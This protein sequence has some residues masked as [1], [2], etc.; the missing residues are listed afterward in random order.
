MNQENR[1]NFAKNEKR[2]EMELTIKKY[3][4]LTKE[5]LY[6][7]LRVRAA[8]F[9]VEQNCAYQDLDRIDSHAYHVTLKDGDEIV[10]YLRV[11]EKGIAYEETSIGRVLTTRRGCGLGEMIM[12]EGIKIAEEMMH[13]DKIKIM[14]QTYAKSFYERF[15]FR[16]TSEEFMEDGI[17]HIMMVRG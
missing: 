6:E 5:E 3:E 1:S 10:A 12:K 2:K 17:P 13:A 7:I 14:A 8:V 16:Q 9:V 4:E 15:G 11:I